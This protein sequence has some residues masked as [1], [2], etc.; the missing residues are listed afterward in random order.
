MCWLQKTFHSLLLPKLL[1]L[2]ELGELEHISSS[3]RYPQSDGKAEN[4]VKTVKRLF[5]KGKETGQ[6][7]FLA[8]LD[9]CNTPT[10]GIDTSPA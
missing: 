7:E 5:S 9:W 1:V 4:T 10:K 8:L 2:P 6:S 3:P